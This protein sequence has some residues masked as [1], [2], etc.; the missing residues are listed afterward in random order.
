MQIA[1]V[2]GGPSGMAAAYAAAING[3]TVTLFESNE[4]LG[5]KMY[6]SGKGRCNLTNDSSV[7]N[8][9]SNVLSNPRFLFSA[10]NAFSPADLMSLVESA[11]VTLK[12]ERG[13]RVFPLSDKSSDVISAWERLL[14]RAGVSVKFSEKVLS[15]EKKA[16][17]FT[18]TSTN[19]EYSF[20]AV[21]VTTGGITYRATG[22]TGDGY[23]FAKS[24]GLSVTDLAPALVGIQADIPHELSGLSLKNVELSV[25]KNGKTLFKEFGEM[26]FTHSGISGPI[27]LTIS[28]RINREDLSALILSLDLKPALS[29]ETLDARLVREFA[30]APNKAIHNV[31]PT[32]MPRSLVEFVL[33]QTGLPG[34]RPCQSVTKG[35]RRSLAQAIKGLTIIPT[36]FED[37]NGAIVTA[38]GVS[39]SEIDPKSMMCKR[40]SG[41]YFA[42]EVLDLDALTGGY[43]LQIA[44]STGYLAGLHAANA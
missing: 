26:L 28:S 35:E 18:I 12:T 31:M 1:V 44:F 23:R 22:S 2:G 3:A 20:D 8:H 34:T 6:I 5:K 32:L 9:M 13:N 17:L 33:D 10:Y 24:F 7:Q 36:G 14:A 15:I 27:A 4:K 43:N 38:G 41:L 21:V 25:V 19:G 39:V 11:G 16:D 29:E 37:F 40:V 30:V 42:G